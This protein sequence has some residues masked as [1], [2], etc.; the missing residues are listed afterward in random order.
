MIITIIGNFHLCKK[1][2]ICLE[3]FDHSINKPLVLFRCGHTLCN[4]CV[5]DLHEK[6]KYMIELQK[7]ANQTSKL[8]EIHLEDLEYYFSNEAWFFDLIKT[9][10]KRY[11]NFLYEIIDKV[12]PRR[13]LKIS[14]EED[15]EPFEE[16]IQ[17]QRMANLLAKDGNGD[18]KQVM[19]DQI[20][21]E[22]LRR[23]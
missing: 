8:L 22:L 18:N 9:N 23:L 7:I 13:T 10:T 21:S 6:K 14:S 1:L 19:R 3:K 15:L 12:M 4:K 17:N 16:V 2:E 20:P 5:D 11:V